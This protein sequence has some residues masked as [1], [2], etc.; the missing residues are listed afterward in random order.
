MISRNTGV[1]QFDDTTHQDL[2]ARSYQ[3]FGARFHNFMNAPVVPDLPSHA[4][5]FSN[6]TFYGYQANRQ[7]V[8]QQRQR[9]RYTYVKQRVTSFFLGRP[10]PLPFGAIIPSPPLPVRAQPSPN[11]FPRA[12]LQ[13]P[14]R[15][16][17]RATQ[18]PNE[19]RLPEDFVTHF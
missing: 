10:R 8:I 2:A 6:N 13:A 18:T 11:P 5:V 19:W 16:R 7:N 4:P 15:Q 17:T 1:R 3:N 14:P 9:T 12:G